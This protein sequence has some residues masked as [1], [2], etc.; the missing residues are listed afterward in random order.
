MS[1]SL[2]RSKEDLAAAVSSA[3]ETAKVINSLHQRVVQ[4]TMLESQP[5]PGEAEAL[6][7]AKAAPVLLMRRERRGEARCSSRP[8]CWWGVRWHRAEHCVMSASS[9]GGGPS[10]R[11]VGTPAGSSPGVRSEQR[12]LIRR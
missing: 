8:V 11:S 7:N 10:F 3:A 12:D 6:R 5:V 1:A 4:N 9:L 2:I